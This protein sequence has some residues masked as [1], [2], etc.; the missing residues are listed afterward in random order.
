MEYFWE[1]DRQFLFH[2]H[3]VS[4]NFVASNKALALYIEN[5]NITKFLAGGDFLLV[6]YYLINYWSSKIFIRQN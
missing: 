3:R 1:L 2:A 5:K 4:N 6:F